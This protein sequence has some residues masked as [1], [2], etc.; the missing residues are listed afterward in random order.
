MFNLP[1]VMTAAMKGWGTHLTREEV[2]N[3]NM[4]VVTG[5][6]A[7]TGAQTNSAG[8]SL[9]RKLGFPEEKMMQTDHNI[10]GAANSDLDV[11]GAVLLRAELNGNVSR[12]IMYICRNEKSTIF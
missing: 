1:L 2:K 5:G 11:M 9:L 4:D 10:I 6:L 3:L 7:D 8:L 12:F